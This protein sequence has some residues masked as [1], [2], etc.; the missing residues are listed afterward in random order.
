LG[1]VKE[2][3]EGLGMGGGA[4]TGKGRNRAMVP[5]PP[6]LSPLGELAG[7]GQLGRL[8]FS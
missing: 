8:S 7:R 1:R 4:G 6:A 2:A 5:A 3:A